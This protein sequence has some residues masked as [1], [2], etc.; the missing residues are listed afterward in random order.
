MVVRY[1]W[2]SEEEPPPPSR[3]PSLAAGNS[4]E[5]HTLLEKFAWLP[6]VA[7][8]SQTTCAVR[9]D[10]GPEVHLG[11]TL[12]LPDLVGEKYPAMVS[13]LDEDCNEI[14]GIR[15][16]DLLVPVATYPGSLRLHV[17]WIQPAGLPAV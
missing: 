12:T 1:R 15:L 4:V 13:Q 3:H 10:Y 17:Y 14:A 2:V 6:G 7:V 8:P 5:S 9:L 16:P 11:R